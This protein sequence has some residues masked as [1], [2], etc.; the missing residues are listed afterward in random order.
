MVMGSHL[1]SGVTDEAPNPG[2]QRLTSPGQ[3]FASSHS[4]TVYLMFWEPDHYIGIAWKPYWPQTSFFLQLA[5]SPTLQRSLLLH[6]RQMDSH[7]LSTRV[8]Q[9][10]LPRKC[11]LKVA[12]R[13]LKPTPES[14]CIYNLGVI[15]GNR[16]QEMEISCYGGQWKPGAATETEQKKDGSFHF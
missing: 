11:I 9:L 6:R 14:D 2:L 12:R 1:D 5:L 8:K 16:Y 13:K 7:F 10:F 4:S 3:H 15:L